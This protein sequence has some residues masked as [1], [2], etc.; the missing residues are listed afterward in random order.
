ME[1]EEEAVNAVAATRYPP[2]GIRGVSVSHR[3]N[4]FGTVP[5]YFRQS[6]ANISIL[7]CRLKAAGVDNLDAILSTDGVDGVFVGPSDL[8]AT[9]G[10]IGNAAHPEVQRTIQHILP[11]PKRTTNRAVSRRRLKRTRVVTTGMGCDRGC[12]R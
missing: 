11:A 8:A 9:L 1:T 6:N 7:R 3:A 5:D 10:Y 4:M 12:R 2:E